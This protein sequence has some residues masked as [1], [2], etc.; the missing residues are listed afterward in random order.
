[1]IDATPSAHKIPIVV[2]AGFLGSGKT[3]LLNN[4]LKQQNGVK[5]AAV[6][7]DFGSVNVDSMLVAKQSEER[8]ELS[9]GCICCEMGED[10]I[11]ATL[12]EIAHPGTTFQAIVIEASGAAEPPDIARSILESDNDYVYFDSLVY[13][14][15][16]PEFETTI[17]RHETLQQHLQA[18]DCLVVNKTD[19]LETSALDN[20]D[21]RLRE[22]NTVAPIL[23]SQHGQVDSRLLLDVE[24]PS[25]SSPQ[26]ALDTTGDDEAHAHH[27]H[28]EYHTMTWTTDSP[29][30]PHRMFAWL[31]DPPQGVYRIKGRI[32]FGGKGLME[33]FILQ[34]VAGRWDVKIADT[35][36]DQIPITE[37][38]FIGDNF[39]ETRV[40]QSL[41]EIIDDDPETLN[42]DTLLDIMEYE[43]VQ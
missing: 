6:V 27:L 2:L 21:S 10:G 30:D 3:S 13:V 22:Y 41:Q 25:R 18:A 28:T 31:D 16:G 29:L 1:M 8:L 9:N 37:L 11:D 14:V 7:N 12:G 19:L 35:G 20:L 38:V 23:H 15:D 33:Q 40:Q 32:N 36:P 43:R 5:I 24:R 17:A 34:S 4:L 42:Q 26:L 39:D